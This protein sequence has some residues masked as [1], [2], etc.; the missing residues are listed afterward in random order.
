MA[1]RI[2]AREVVR[3]F[4][5]ER[6]SKAESIA[7]AKKAAVFVNRRLAALE[8]AGLRSA[9]TS[10]GMRKIDIS[11]IDSKRKA[12]RAI[13]KAN[14]LLNNPL[15][16]PAKVKSMIKQAQREYGTTS[17]RV[18]WVTEEIVQEENG[19]V[20]NT[21][22][23]PKAVPTG[24]K[25]DLK[26][27][28]AVSKQ[29]REYWTWYKKVAQDFLD[30]EEAQMYWEEADYN[31]YDARRMAEKAIMESKEESKQQYKDQMVKH[32]QR[33]GWLD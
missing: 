1:T 28:A 4:D 17:T 30:S 7:E 29:M 25:T 26:S 23:K 20:K 10:G 24:V 31:N 22:L 6:L 2:K 5:A 12:V 18:R 11:K 33:S 27:W 13:N 16:S 21:I 3:N 8:K 9:A 19:I 14:Q 15:S 32:Y